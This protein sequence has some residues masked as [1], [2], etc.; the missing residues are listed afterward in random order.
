MEDRKFVYLAKNC[1]LDPSLHNSCCFDIVF[2]YQLRS[3][4]WCADVFGSVDNL[5][6]PGYS[7]SDVCK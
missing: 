2:A 5:L 3:Y 1:F 4:N 7:E 6:D